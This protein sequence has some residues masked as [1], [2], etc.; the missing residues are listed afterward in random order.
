MSNNSWLIGGR[1]RRARFRRGFRGRR[2]GPGC[3]GC[4]FVLLVIALGYILL[5]VAR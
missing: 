3:L 4:G 2:F 5:Q 1:I